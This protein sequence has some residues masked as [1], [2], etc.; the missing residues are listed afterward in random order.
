MG[1]AE[2]KLEDKQEMHAKILNGARKVFLAKGYDQ[3]S[4]RNIAS[5]INYSP[6]SIYFYFKD[7]SEIFHELHKE[8]FQL[9]LSQLKVLEKVGDPFEQLKASGRVFIQF[10]QENKDY[11]NLMFIVDDSV[12]DSAS[13]GF[14]IA[15]E[16]IRYMHGMVT[17]CQ[18]KGKFK[19][20][21]TEYFTFM[22][23]SVL[24]GICA[25][26]CKHRNTS[27]VGKTDE[28]LMHNGYESFVGL[29]E[30]G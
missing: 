17:E 28:E 21:D 7:K 19:N 29:L 12:K 5:E 11:Y 14:K 22:I 26:F 10:A 8:G 25:L 3:T 15:E 30:K 27:F 9:L 18:L 20:M 1:I 6:G 2:R 24:H 16:A 23:I 4:M 13:E